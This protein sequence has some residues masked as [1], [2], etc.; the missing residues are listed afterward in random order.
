MFACIWDNSKRIQARNLFDHNIVLIGFMGAGK[1]TISKYLST[2]FAM[3]V[4]E[5]D[6]VIAQREGMS[7]SD[8]FEVHG[9]RY[10]RDAE[11]DLLI[12]MQAKRNM[13]ISCGGGT[14][15][16]ECNVAEMKKNGRVVLLSAKPETIY[17][18]VKDSHDR[19]LIEDNKN[20][21]FISELMEKRREKYTAAADIVIQTDGK[22]EL[23]ICEELIWRLME[24]DGKVK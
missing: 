12:E 5:M 18:R 21:P 17:E 8:I 20:V 14:P 3:E 15:M 16:R 1:S 10:F 2:M 6:Q 22:N 13:V 19:P 7:I 4:I 23:Q 9:E 24:M 11:T